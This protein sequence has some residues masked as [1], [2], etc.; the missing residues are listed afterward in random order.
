M[1]ANLLCGCAIASFVE[2]PPRLPLPSIDVVRAALKRNAEQFPNRR[3][4]RVTV[5]A[6]GEPRK[7]FP[8]LAS[9]DREEFEWVVAADGRWRTT[10]ATFRSGKLARTRDEAFD[11]ARKTLVEGDF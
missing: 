3:F 5:D 6:P 11:G 4:K 1:L 8:A 10:S 7:E 9:G 2:P